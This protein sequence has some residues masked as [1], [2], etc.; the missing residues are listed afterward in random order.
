MWLEQL[1]A[2]LSAVSK[3]GSLPAHGPQSSADGR[4]CSRE[5]SQLLA[6]LVKSSAA[7]RSFV[8]R[9]TVPPHRRL[10]V[11]TQI[12]FLLDKSPSMRS[13]TAEEIALGIIEALVDSLNEYDWANV[14][15]MDTGGKSIPCDSAVRTESATACVRQ[16]DRRGLTG[17]LAY[18]RLTVCWRRFLWLGFGGKLVPMDE[19]NKAALKVRRTTPFAVQ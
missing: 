12:L 7:A 2:L 14:I 18:H 8:D 15:L 6:P 4:N 11:P 3:C 17:V 13:S 5:V 16:S 10:V 1:T 19:T 9:C